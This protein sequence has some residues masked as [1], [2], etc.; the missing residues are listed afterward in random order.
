M[1]LRFRR[2]F[3]LAPRL[4]EI[5]E[6]FVE[7]I[8]AVFESDDRSQVLRAQLSALD[9]RLL[10]YEMG[11]AALHQSLELEPGMLTLDGVLGYLKDFEFDLEN[12]NRRIVKAFGLNIIYNDPQNWL[13]GVAI[14]FV[15]GRLP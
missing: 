5:F 4:I 12:R 1:T 2:I 14:L 7:P 15:L 6:A 10:Y 11:I 3:A 8:E 9:N 13:A